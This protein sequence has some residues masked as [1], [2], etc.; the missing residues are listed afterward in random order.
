MKNL[1]KNTRLAS[2]INGGGVLSVPAGDISMGFREGVGAGFGQTFIC[3]CICWGGPDYM[4]CCAS[5]EALSCRPTRSQSLRTRTERERNRKEQYMNFK[6]LQS[7]CTIQTLWDNAELLTGNIHV[8]CSI[9]KL[10]NLFKTKSYLGIF[11]KRLWRVPVQSTP[12]VCVYVLTWWWGSD[13]RVDPPGE[14]LAH[15]NGG[16]SWQWV[17]Q[18]RQNSEGDH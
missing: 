3:T 8:T 12:A 15:S 13:R 18:V 16:L 1:N 10:L 17:V 4:W 11:L 14:L 9:L 7:D 2:V 5:A 6:M